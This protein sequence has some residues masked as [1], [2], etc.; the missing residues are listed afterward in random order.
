MK[1][2]VSLSANTA[3]DHNLVTLFFLIL[4]QKTL[5]CSL[6]WARHWTMSWVFVVC[7]GKTLFYYVRSFC[8]ILIWLQSLLV[9]NIQLI[10]LN[11]TYYYIVKLYKNIVYFGILYGTWPVSYRVNVVRGR[12]REVETEVKAELVLFLV[13]CHR[14]KM[15]DIVSTFYLWTKPS[16]EI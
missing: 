13:N 1:I 15:T 6:S 3:A 5:W 9:Y 12:G 11:S 2:L 14:D 10:K 8:L 16:V 4:L 7:L